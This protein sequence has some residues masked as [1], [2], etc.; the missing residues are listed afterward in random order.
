MQSSAGC[1]PQVMLDRQAAYWQKDLPSNHGRRRHLRRGCLPEG[2]GNG[3]GECPPGRRCTPPASRRRRRCRDPGVGGSCPETAATLVSLHVEMT[4]RPWAAARLVVLVQ[5]EASGL[6]RPG[7]VAGD[8]PDP[9]ADTLQIRN[10]TGRRRHGRKLHAEPG[11]SHA[12][13][14][15]TAGRHP[16]ATHRLWTHAGAP[17]SGGSPASGHSTCGGT[18]GRLWTAADRERLR[19]QAHLPC[20]RS[21]P[22]RDGGGR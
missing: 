5:R 20:P 17:G 16:A 15:R 18:R 6:R 22:R 7:T 10:L 8:A 14:A 21:R 12:R 1:G 11:P 2:T 3:V 9:R 19:W 13:A 4:D